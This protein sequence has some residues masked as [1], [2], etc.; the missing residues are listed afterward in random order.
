[1]PC[2]LGEAEHL[3]A[4]WMV[5]RQMMRIFTLPR[6]MTVPANQSDCSR[7]EEAVSVSPVMTIDTR[8]ATDQAA[9]FVPDIDLLPKALP[10]IRS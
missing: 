4:Q 10:L 9:T 6:E 1:M 7:A 2:D 3:R 5:I 8:T